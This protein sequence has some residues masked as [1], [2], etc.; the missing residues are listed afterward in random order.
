MHHARGI[1]NTGQARSHETGSLRF[2]PRNVLPLGSTLAQSLR[3]C[4]QRSQNNLRGRHPHRQLRDLARLRGR[5]AWGVDD[6]DESYPLSYT[7]DLVRL[8]ASVKIAIGSEKLTIAFKQA[9]IVIVEGYRDTLKDEGC[10]FVLAER[11]RNLERLGVKEIMPP[12]DFWEKLNQRPA[13]RRVIPRVAREA[14]EAEL[15]EG[16]HYR[17]VRREA[18]TGSLGRQRFLAIGEWK[19]GYIAREAKAMT[20]SACAWL[21][22]QKRSSR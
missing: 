11:E 9:C 1:S 16:I 5:L 22:G 12:D 19:G 15:P 10:P 14:L 21:D 7:N 8:A 3:R 2:F 13:I 6:F 18:G 20:P 4:E 17:V